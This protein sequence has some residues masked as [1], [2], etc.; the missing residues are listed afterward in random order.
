MCN[1][2]QGRFR[3]NTRRLGVKTTIS[4]VYAGQLTKITGKQ[5]LHLSKQHV[6]DRFNLTLGTSQPVF[7]GN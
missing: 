6:P 3:G 2:A 1:A 5:P 7:E 4:Q